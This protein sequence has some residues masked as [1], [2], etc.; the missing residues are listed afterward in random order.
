MNAASGHHTSFQKL[1]KSNLF[2]NLNAYDA[3]IISMPIFA[4]WK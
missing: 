2:E 3:Y 4:T 1:K